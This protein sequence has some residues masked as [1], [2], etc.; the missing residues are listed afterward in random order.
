MFAKM[1]LLRGHSDALDTYLLGVSGVAG[2][3]ESK[4][5]DL[6]VDIPQEERFTEYSYMSDSDLDVDSDDEEDGVSP[7][8]S[9]AAQHPLPLSGPTSPLLTPQLISPRRMGR[10]V[11]VKGHAF[12]TWNAL[13]YY[14]YTNKIVFRTSGSGPHDAPQTPECSAKSMYMLAD[15]FGLDELKALALQSLRSQLSTDNIVRE[16]F[17]TFTSL[18]PEIQDIEVEFLVENLPNLTGEIDEMLR[19]ICDGVRPQCFNVL[20][21]IVCHTEL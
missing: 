6:D 15:K 19:S 3:A 14:L 5:V 9:T 20:R 21:K 13:L 10:V 4:M 2:F 16:A 11:V 8:A 12:K 1:A 18:Y 17:S 7:E